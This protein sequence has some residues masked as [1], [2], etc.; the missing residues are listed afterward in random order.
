MLRY[1]SD[2]IIVGYIKQLLSTF[3]LPKCKVF[4]SLEEFK[5]Y[6]SGKERIG[7][8]KNYKDGAPYIV[9]LNADNVIT[10]ETI[11]IFNQYYPNITSTMYLKNNIY[12]MDCH[13]YL[14]DFLRFLR[15][16]SNLNLMT[17]YNCFSGT[18]LSDDLYKYL[19][20]PVK[21]NTDYTVAL[22]GKNYAFTFVTGKE[23][24]IIKEKLG[25]A[26]S[27]NPHIK[28]MSSFD[29]PY[30]ITTPVLEDIFNENNYKLII[31]LTSDNK[32]P[33]SIIEGDYTLNKRAYTNV[34][35]NFDENIIDEYNRMNLDRYLSDFQL[36][37]TKLT[38]KNESYPVADRLLEYLTG[39]VIV[40][41]DKISKNIIDAKY[42][43][44]IN[45]GNNAYTDESGK[46]TYSQNHILSKLSPLNDSFTNKER[47]RFLDA[48][49]HSKYKNS[50]D[51]LGYVDK[52]VESAIGELETGVDY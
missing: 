9:A 44:Y 14:G 26:F 25:D 40:P 28:K 19:I 12:D 27:N 21:S 52:D 16:Y 32:T 43:V 37:D 29:K 51:I 18:T 41:G 38:F 33:V 11:Y 6:A 22:S 47:I 39:M 36:F 8:I 50:H 23:L 13:K 46:T 42:K 5:M 20:I 2:N 45:C 31:R 7:I 48:V 15:D 34:Q 49:S 1:N 17:M 4:G 24:S 10:G 35:F 30:K 3:N